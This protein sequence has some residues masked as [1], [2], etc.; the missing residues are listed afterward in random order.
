MEITI[1]PEEKGFSA[2]IAS[3]HIH[4][5]WDTFDELLYNV[6]EALE[7]YYEEEKQYALETMASSKFYF[8]LPKVDY[9]NSVKRSHAYSIAA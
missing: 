3:L 7:L 2:S 8:S 6:R 4:T 1:T 5:Q 9:T